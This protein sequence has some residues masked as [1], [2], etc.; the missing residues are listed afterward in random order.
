M[1]NT[2]PRSDWKNSNFS[3]YHY[4]DGVKKGSYLLLAFEFHVKNGSTKSD[5]RD[6]INAGMK[7]SFLNGKFEDIARFTKNISTLKIFYSK[8]LWGNESGIVEVC[9]LTSAREVLR[10]YQREVSVIAYSF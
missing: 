8:Y 9:N 4:I 7:I 2:P 6:A 3:G 10:R 5:V 1:Y